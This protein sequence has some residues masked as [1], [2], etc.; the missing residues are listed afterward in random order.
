LAKGEDQLVSIVVEGKVDEPFDKPIGEWRAAYGKGKEERLRYLCTLL[1]LDERKIDH[2]Y[3]QLV[4][5][6]AS[7]LIEANRFTARNA[8]MLI[9]SFSQK[10]TGFHEY[11]QFLQLYGAKGEVSSLTFGKNIDGINLYFGWARTG[12]S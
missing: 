1:E 3:Y 9:H 2:I 10:D 4:H 11:C 8:L 6:T 7:A 12:L 5:R